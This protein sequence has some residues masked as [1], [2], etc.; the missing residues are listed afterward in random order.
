MES[1]DGEKLKALP[2]AVPRAGRGTDE[3]GDATGQ[4][5]GYRL[6]WCWVNKLCESQLS[7][8]MIEDR[9]LT[10]KQYESVNGV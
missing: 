7:A 4:L 1:V 5:A 8:H 3:P 6:R 2:S 9:V 10:G